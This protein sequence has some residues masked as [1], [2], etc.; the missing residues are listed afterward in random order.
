MG[1][2][3]VPSNTGMRYIATFILKSTRYDM[4][5]PMRNKVE[6]LTKFE[7]FHRNISAKTN[8]V[9][10][11]LRSDN[12]GEYK[13]AKMKALCEKLKISQEYTV[14]YN[15]EQNGLAERF[16]RTLREMVR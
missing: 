14:P 15:P 2:F 8:I 5:Y 3:E 4:A 12:G 13:N 9:I 10:K 6:V 16:N 11:R 1:P 7:E